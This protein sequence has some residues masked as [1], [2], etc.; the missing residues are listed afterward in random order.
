[1][2]VNGALMS[3]TPPFDNSY[4]CNGFG[5]LL[6]VNFEGE[7]ILT[8]G[9]TDTTACNYDDSAILDDELANMVKHGTQM[10][11]VMV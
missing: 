2:D 6:S 11:M 1:M 8:Y 3:T 10:V 5:S 4:S 9:C 7:Y